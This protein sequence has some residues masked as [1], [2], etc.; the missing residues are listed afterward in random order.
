MY[1][2]F[3]MHGQKN[4]KLYIYIPILTQPWKNG[5]S[6]WT[7]NLKLAGE[8][9]TC[10]EDCRQYEYSCC[11]VEKK[12]SATSPISNTRL[13]TFYKEI[14]TFGRPKKHSGRNKILILN[15]SISKFKLLNTHK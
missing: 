6:Q 1:S 2:Q 14:Y 13:R 9:S 5:K 10:G 11:C 12:V 4:I 7:T 3:M 8:Y 15:F